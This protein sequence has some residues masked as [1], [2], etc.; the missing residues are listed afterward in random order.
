MKIYRAYYYFGCSTIYCKAGV[1]RFVCIV[2][3][4][5][6]NVFVVSELLNDKVI[7]AGFDK[8]F[9]NIFY[10]FIASLKTYYTKGLMLF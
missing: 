1:C 7:R 6:A 3:T 4:K 8:M 10:Y 2:K 9:Y 5:L